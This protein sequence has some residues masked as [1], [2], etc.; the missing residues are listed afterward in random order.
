MMYFLNLFSLS[1][2][3]TGKFNFIADWDAVFARSSGG[4]GV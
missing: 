2:N 4:N 1:G 3:R